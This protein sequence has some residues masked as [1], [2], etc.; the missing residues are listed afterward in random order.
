[1]GKIV[2][3]VAIVD[4]LLGFISFGVE[5]P[6][7]VLYAPLRLGCTPPLVSRPRVCE[8]GAL[9]YEVPVLTQGVVSVA[10][11]GL[12]GAE[13]LVRIRCGHRF[14]PVWPLATL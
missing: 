11:E 9:A 12:D 1:M 5:V 4:A 3:G 6:A 10:S 13:C 8:M 2:V 7:M 14:A